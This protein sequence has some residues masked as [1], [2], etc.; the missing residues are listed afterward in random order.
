MPTIH[1]DTSCMYVMYK[2]I[3]FLLCVVIGLFQKVMSEIGYEEPAIV[4]SM[5]IFKVSFCYVSFHAY[6]N[7]KIKQLAANYVH[8]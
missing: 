1:T 2:S 3:H 7:E 4:Q 8:Q 5:Y 6:F